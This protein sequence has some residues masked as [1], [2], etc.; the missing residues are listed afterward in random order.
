[1]SNLCQGKLF[2]SAYF[3]KC[4]QLWDEYVVLVASCAC[5]SMGSATKPIER[6]QLMQFLMGL[7][8]DYQMLRSTIL[9]LKPLPSVSQA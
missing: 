8:D 4:K 6:Q 9:M 7:N 2:V 1:M 5:Q 3:T